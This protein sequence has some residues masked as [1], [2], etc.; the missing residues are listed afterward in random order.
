MNNMLIKS[1][2]EIFTGFCRSIAVGRRLE[3]YTVGEKLS[4]LMLENDINSEQLT[5]ELN[6]NKNAIKKL[7]NGES[8]SKEMIAKI[9]KYFNVDED[10]FEDKELYDVII[11]DNGFPIGRYDTN[12]RALEVKQELDKYIFECH[13][14]GTPI[15]IEMPKE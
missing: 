7:M 10:Y 11:T 2:D 8:H 14:K 4:K 12:K 1:Q 5:K 6:V 13:K 3:E 15:A 9:A